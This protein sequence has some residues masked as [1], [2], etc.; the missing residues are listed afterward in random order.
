M[1]RRRVS[2]PL[3]VQQL[4]DAVKIIRYKRQVPDVERITRYMN[5]THNVSDDE[6]GRQINYCVRD[7][8][9]K[10]IKKVGS[11]GSKCGIEQEGYKLPEDKLEKDSH[12]WYCFECHSGGDVICCT[13]C[14]RVYH[15]SCISKDDLPEDDV[16]NKFVCSI[17]NRCSNRELTP[18]IKK[19]QLN[20]LLKYTATKMKDRLPVALTDRQ[21]PSSNSYLSE[22]F[23]IQGQVKSPSIDV[24]SNF[25]W[26]L[27]DKDEWRVDYLIYRPIDLHIMESK[28]D[29]K[30][31]EHLE[32]F[33]ADIQT[34]VHNYVIYHGVHSNMADM[35]RLML[36]DC[37]T[38]LLEILECWRCYKHCNDKT[39][40]NW[41]ITPCKPPHEL[42]YAK[43]KGCPYWP[44]KIMKDNE[45]TCEVKFFGGIHERATVE[46]IY[47][48]PISV[49][50]HTLQIKRTS[51]WNKAFEEVK[52]HQKQLEKLRE[53][54]DNYTK[55]FVD[56]SSDESDTP[57][58][59]KDIDDSSRNKSINFSLSPVAN[60]DKIEAKESN[61]ERS[62][63]HDKPKNSSETVA[64]TP[65]NEIK[66]TRPRGRPKKSTSEHVTP[67]PAQEDKL[68]KP[69]QA[70]KS[71]SPK[72]RGRPPKISGAPAAKKPRKSGS[73]SLNVEDDGPSGAE[74]P[75]IKIPSLDT[76]SND[77]KNQ[78][79]AEDHNISSTSGKLQLAAK[80]N[81][82]EIV[83]SSSSQNPIKRSVKTQTKSLEVKPSKEWIEKMEEEFEQ[84]KERL[85]AK[86]RKEH[87]QEIA[88]L[89]QAH[90]AILS[91]TKRKQWCVNCELEAIYHCCWNTS[92]CS[93]DCQ[94]AHWAADHKRHCRR[95]R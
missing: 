86:L 21:P 36:R 20:R 37:N 27:N 17:C 44:A 4:W 91:E 2:C 16:K 70:T 25:K 74:P 42:V 9:L 78:N 15:L 84:E 49:N 81:E 10:V 7:G 53:E 73:F 57:D 22:R 92:Y 6:V 28:A 51:S 79:D 55:P 43:S 8:L 83:S 40:R 82:E 80:G 1:S 31:Y 50:I 90:N 52:R 58:V 48:R 72:S 71:S 14:H 33:R 32:E 64:K 67:T 59:D 69:P 23:A 61:D 3:T 45:E 26:I 77:I 41:F 56:S 12:D 29:C 13:S 93:P 34:I 24:P 76:D 54:T 94:L 65:V 46:K 5:R 47:I 35:A 39:L 18:N 11:K 38:D 89:R 19:S 88:L 85:I 66:T 95:K 68:S 63:Q 87:E 62:S 30:K 60:N 75:E